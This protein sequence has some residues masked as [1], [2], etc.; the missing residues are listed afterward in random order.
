[1]HR[2]AQGFACNKNFIDELAAKP[3]VARVKI[4]HMFNGIKNIWGSIF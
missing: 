4:H 3:G 1:M 2:K